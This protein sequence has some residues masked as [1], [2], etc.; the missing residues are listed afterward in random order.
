MLSQLSFLRSHL[1]LIW[2]GLATAA[3]VSL[4]WT[5]GAGNN[6][7]SAQQQEVSYMYA[8]KIVCVPTFGRASPAL[9]PG[10]YRTAVN[11]HN[12]WPQPA[13]L[14]KWVT[15]SPPQGQAAISGKHIS[16]TLEPFQAF[17]I[18]C[19][20]M[21]KDFCLQGKHVPGGKGFLI[22][23]AD[24]NIDVVGVYTS[25]EIGRTGS[26]QIGGGLSMDVEY[27]QPKVSQGPILTVTPPTA[28][29]T[30]TIT[31]TPTQ[32]PT[33]IPTLTPTTTP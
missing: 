13:H 2:V 22:I 24:Q 5:A 26:A 23:Q 7:A 19:V 28:T 29:P 1:K 18:D 20:H 12:P 8:V 31:P 27:V 16:E 11:V 4:A 17:D 15:L 30:M 21:A 33:L 9:V 14:V 32:T 6:Q 3:L 10:I 25:E